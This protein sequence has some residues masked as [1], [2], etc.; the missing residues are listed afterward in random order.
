[1]SSV[2]WG[3][4]GLSRGAHGYAAYPCAYP[5]DRGSKVAEGSRL[6]VAVHG[7]RFGV[8]GLWGSDETQALPSLGETL[9]IIG[10][11]SLSLGWVEVADIGV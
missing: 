10:V 4:R 7:V 5:W 6:E 11:M 1:M 9:L 3:T 2:A 8:W